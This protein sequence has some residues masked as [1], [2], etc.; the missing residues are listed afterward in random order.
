MA[1]QNSSLTSGDV[2]ITGGT[3]FLGTYIISEL[4]NKGYRVK[5]IRRSNKIP[6]FMPADI[7]NNVEWI[8]GDILDI[9]RLAE[10]MEGSDIV[11]HAAAKV[12]FIAKERKEMYKTNIDGT[13]NVVNVALEKKIKKLIY[14]SSV[15]ALGRRDDGA[16]IN[17]GKQ[18]EETKLFT[19]YAIS[20][21]HA[22]ME[23]WR[24]IAEGLDAVVINPSTILGYGDWNTTSC[25]LFKSAYN[26]FPW[27]TNGANGFVDVHDVAKIVV[28]LLQNNI[29]AERFLISSDNWSFRQLLNSIA[30]GFAKKHPS[31]EASALL[32]SIAWRI[33]KL[34]SLF[35]GQRPLLT[36]ESAKIAQSKAHF[37]NSKIQQYLPGFTFTPLK[38]SIDQACKAYLQHMQSA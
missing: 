29:S 34:K 26:E 24:A 28:L 9:I 17:E 19:H 6:F 32:G 36:K 38:L 1:D 23:V 3:G 21:Y 33:E 14:I 10:V 11:I 4:L 27:Y 18:W 5:A 2:F 31:K 15:A 8:E 37:D 30:D 12:S 13:I 20:K 22:E 7:A 16:M 35:T 25:A